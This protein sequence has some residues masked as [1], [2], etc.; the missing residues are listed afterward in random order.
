MAFILIIQDLG[1]S[2]FVKMRV[3]VCYLLKSQ[4]PKYDT[5]AQTGSAGVIVMDLCCEVC[6][7]QS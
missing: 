4:L 6:G 5:L 3:F 7:I 1:E 2:L